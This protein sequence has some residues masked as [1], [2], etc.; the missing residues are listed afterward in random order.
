MV[1]FQRFLHWLLQTSKAAYHWL[2][3]PVDT[4]RAAT[5]AKGAVEPELSLSTN[6]PPRY[7]KR[8]SLLTDAESELFSQLLNEIGAEYRVFTKVRLGDV[9]YLQNLTKDRK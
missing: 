5:D 4:P 8:R 2:A 9:M 7:A 6:E 1:L 3:G